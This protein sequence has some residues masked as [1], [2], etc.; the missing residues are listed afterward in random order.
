MLG[1]DLPHVDLQSASQQRSY[2]LTSTSAMQMW[3]DWKADSRF[4]G[5]SSEKRFSPNLCILGKIQNLGQVSNAHKQPTTQKVRIRRLPCCWILGLLK[6]GSEADTLHPP[7]LTPPQN[8]FRTQIIAGFLSIGNF[9][10]YSPKNVSSLSQLRWWC[11]VERPTP[12]ELHL[13]FP[14]DARR[15]ESSGL[16]ISQLSPGGWRL[17]FQG[18]LTEI[19]L[20][21]ASWCIDRYLS[22]RINTCR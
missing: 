21:D 20:S 4:C 18:Y 10:A 13:S 1:M 11:P 15:I 2:L 16:Y 14:A 6:T 5:Q 8:R 22:D 19:H 12:I 17:P 7:P 3:S 9:A